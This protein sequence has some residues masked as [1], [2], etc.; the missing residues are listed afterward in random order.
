MGG[1]I[2]IE[3]RPWGRENCSVKCLEHENFNFFTYLFLEGKF[4]SLTVNKAIKRRLSRNLIVFYV[5]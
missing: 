2:F 3:K 5:V 4:N 1:F